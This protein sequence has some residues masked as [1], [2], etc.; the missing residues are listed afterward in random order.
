MCVRLLFEYFLKIIIPYISKLTMDKTHQGKDLELKHEV[1]F[2][3][4]ISGSIKSNWKAGLLILFIVT[5][6]FVVAYE[7]IS[8]RKQSL[9]NNGECRKL[10]FL[11]LGKRIEYSNHRKIGLM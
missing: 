7:L 8:L 5:A 4:A 10:L 11:L 3:T 6:C 9:Q 2:L 1:F